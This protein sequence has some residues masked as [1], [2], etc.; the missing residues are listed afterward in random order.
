MGGHVQDERLRAVLDDVGRRT[1]YLHVL[2]SFPAAPEAQKPR[3]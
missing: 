1:S 2:G 3:S